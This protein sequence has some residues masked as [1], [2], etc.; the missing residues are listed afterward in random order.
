M[1]CAKPG[2]CDECKKPLKETADLARIVYTCSNCG[3]EGKGEGE[4]EGESSG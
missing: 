1:Q 4:E 2:N 3:D